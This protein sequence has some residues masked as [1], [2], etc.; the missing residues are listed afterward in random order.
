MLGEGGG[1]A[2]VSRGPYIKIRS[3]KT[4]G[5]NFF[6]FFYVIFQHFLALKFK[7]LNDEHMSRNYN[8]KVGKIITY[9]KRTTSVPNNRNHKLI[10]STNA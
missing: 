4:L 1:D 8:I 9:L 7:L 2:Q 6:F 10:P 3:Q 5:V